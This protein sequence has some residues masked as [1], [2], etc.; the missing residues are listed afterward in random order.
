L[1]VQIPYYESLPDPEKKLVEPVV[2]IQLAQEKQ[3]ET[4][5]LEIKKQRQYLL[6]YREIHLSDLNSEHPILMT[7]TYN[8]EKKQVTQTYF[9][10]SEIDSIQ[11]LNAKIKQP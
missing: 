6:G 10:L 9:N 1:A 5:Y 3:N 8:L 4:A 2:Y 7:W 11:I